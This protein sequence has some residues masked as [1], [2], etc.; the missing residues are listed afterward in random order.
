[1]LVTADVDRVVAGLD[2]SASQM[3]FRPVLDAVRSVLCAHGVDADR[4]QIPMTKVL[5]FRHPTL[6]GVILTWHRQ[7]A[8]ADTSLVSHDQATAAGLPLVGPMVAPLEENG[9][10]RNPYFYV[11]GE[12]DWLYE[13]DLE[14][15]EH[16]FDVF[17]TMRADGFRYYACFRLV[18]PGTALP[19]VVSLASKSPFPEDLR[20][21]LEGLR[22]LLGLGVYAAYRT[23]QAHKIA[24][25]YVG[26]TTGPKVLEGHMVRGSSQTVRAGIMFCDVRGFTALSERVGVA[27]IPIMNQLFEAVGDEAERRGGEIL[28]FIGDAMLLMF[29][30]DGTTEADVAEAMVGTVRAALPRVRAVA[31]DTGYALAAGFGG[32]IG[33]VIYGN[34]GTPE[35]LDFTVMGPAVNLASRLEGLCKPLGVSA[36]F[37]EAVHTDCE[38]RKGGGTHA[39][40]GIADPVPVWT[41]SEA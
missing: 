25:S 23:S 11:W 35:R 19:A 22:S 41:L 13:C 21:R 18:M 37:S 29:P 3:D 40:K 27:I 39:L 2:A 31:Q 33:D 1:M 34:I 14:R 16:D 26:R 36:V 6:W 28:K 8:F 7:R 5:G 20:S 12:R 17:E 38:E 32:H 24:V 10:P 15:A 9:M 30:L 4:V